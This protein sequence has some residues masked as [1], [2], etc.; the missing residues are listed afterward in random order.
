M[1]EAG[2]QTAERN[3]VAAEVVTL[4]PETVPDG[5]YFIGAASGKLYRMVQWVDP[6][7][8]V[9]VLR[10]WRG[11]QADSLAFLRN[12][13]E[14]DGVNCADM[15]MQAQGE[16][17]VIVVGPEPLGDALAGT[18]ASQAEVG[19]EAPMLTQEFEVTAEVAEADVKVMLPPLLPEATPDSPEEEAVPELSLDELEAVAEETAER[20]QELEDFE[21]AVAVYEQEN[22]FP[23]ADDP[24]P[25]AEIPPEIA[26]I[27]W[28]PARNTKMDY[29]RALAGVLRDTQQSATFEQMAVWAV[30][31]G[32]WPDE[33]TA[34]RSLKP[35]WSS[36]LR[37]DPS[38]RK[39]GRTIIP[40]ASAEPQEDLFSVPPTRAES[41][42]ESLAGEA[43]CEETARAR[44]GLVDPEAADVMVTFSLPLRLLTPKGLELLRE[45]FCGQEAA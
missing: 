5:C 12:Y 23:V 15:R 37:L 6:A 36:Y 27:Q 18:G 41:L 44:L 42:A 32:V 7:Q 33:G 13:P 4:T 26:A 2:L 38:F 40:P 39:Q 20:E 3:Q 8:Q 16:Q 28:D 21:S 22:P 31:A 30:A 14:P 1:Y 35:N 24:P 17:A 25:A 43:F 34:V 11:A 19:T 9:Y 45:R 10:C 29:I